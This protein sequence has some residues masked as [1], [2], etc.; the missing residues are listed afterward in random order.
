[1]EFTGQKA[2]L[3]WGLTDFLVPFLTDYGRREP[4]LRS[5]KIS[6][7]QVDAQLVEHVLRDMP[8][9]KRLALED[10]DFKQCADRDR[11]SFLNPRL[12]D[13]KVQVI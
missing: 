8:S 6:R 13:P 12:S 5:L 9:M 7:V 10:V 3:D 1:M 2:D 4:T 11:S